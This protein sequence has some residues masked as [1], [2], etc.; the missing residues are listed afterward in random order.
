MLLKSN[1]TKL[2]NY[3]Y[4]TAAWFR[5]AKQLIKLFLIDNIML[6][7]SQLGLGGREFFTTLLEVRELEV[8]YRC[9]HKTAWSWMT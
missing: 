6:K 7:G 5:V 3:N 4:Y 1:S 2:D 8:N 9:D